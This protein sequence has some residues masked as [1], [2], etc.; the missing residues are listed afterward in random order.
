MSPDSHQP[1]TLLQHQQD[2][3]RLAKTLADIG[4]I[5]SGTVQKQLLTCGKPRCRCHKDPELRHG[6]YW[7]WTSKE[8]GRTISRKLTP[9]EAEIIG[10]WIENRRRLDATLK[11]MMQISRRV[12]PLL[13]QEAAKR[14]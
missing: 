8:R 5:W 4:F 7:Y 10:Q 2:H 12:F 14:D 13:L 3:A 1:G 6:P 9:E 11:Q